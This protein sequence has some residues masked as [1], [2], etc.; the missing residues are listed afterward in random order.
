ML[1]PDAS[2]AEQAGFIHG[3]AECRD[4]MAR[5]VENQ[6]LPDIAASIRAN[7]NPAWGADPGPPPERR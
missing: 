1:H 3:A 4:M 5:F 2:I 6:G 7:W